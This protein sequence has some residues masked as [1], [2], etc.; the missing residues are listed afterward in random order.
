MPEPYKLLLLGGGHAHVMTLRRWEKRAP[1][2]SSSSSAASPQ[3]R[4]ALV[5]ESATSCYSG[6]LPGVISGLYAPEQALVALEPLCAAAGA[7]FLIGKARRVSSKTKEVEVE[8][9]VD[10][11]KSTQTLRLR[12][13]TLSLDVGSTA[14]GEFM[15]VSKRSIAAKP[16]HSLLERLGPF[17]EA[18]DDFAAASS[19]SSS[20]SSSAAA[21]APLPSVVVVGGGAAGI[22][23]AAAVAARL[24]RAAAAAM[25]KEKRAKKRRGSL[26]SSPSSRGRGVCSQK[27]PAPPRPWSRES[28]RGRGCAWWRGEGSSRRRRPCFPLA[29]RRGKKRRKKKAGRE[30]EA[31]SK[32]RSTTT[33]PP[34]PLLLVPPLPLP[35]SSRQTSC[36]GARDRAR[37]PGFGTGRTSLWTKKGSFEWTRACGAAAA[38]TPPPPRL[39]RPL[40]RETARV[41]PSPSIPLLLPLLL[42]GQGSTPCGRGSRSS[43]PTCA[44]PSSR[45]RRGSGMAGLPSL[46]LC[47]C[48]CRWHGGP[49]RAR[50]GPRSRCS[51]SRTAGRSLCGRGGGSRPSRARGSGC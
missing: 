12:Y 49:P 47:L 13:E 28:S 9:E 24:K 16:V 39:G 20:S 30:L 10:E 51:P 35:C 21:T 40:P 23:I 27:S 43:F 31:S 14:K 34:L 42:P 4:L 5:S 36:S 37:T 25:K 38:P 6:M 33:A 46:P 17:F 29:E 8:V 50:A 11:G 18:C 7:D 1:T 44:R 45:A 3:Q 41:S 19:S 15:G 48:L 22:E 26:H 32:S 2:S